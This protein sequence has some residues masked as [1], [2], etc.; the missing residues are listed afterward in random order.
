MEDGMGSNEIYLAC[1][2]VRALVLALIAGALACGSPPEP[3]EYGPGNNGLP[4]RSLLSNAVTLNPKALRALIDNPLND[5]LLD[6]SKH[7]YMSLQ[8]TD[9]RARDVMEYIVSC[10]LDRSAQVKYLEP[11]SHVTH[12]WKGELGL[13]PSW[14]K[15]KPSEECLHLVSSCLFARTNRLGRQ[16]PIRIQGQNLRPRAK[17]EITTKYPQ[18]AQEAGAQG[19]RGVTEGND[20]L[21]FSQGWEPGYV[22][23]CMPSKSITLA[24]PAPSRCAKTSLRVCKGVRGC[25]PEDARFLREKY[26]PCD[27]APLTFT[28]PDQGFYGVMTKS[29]RPA[30]VEVVQRRADAGAYPALE[31]DVFSF[32]EGA[33]FGNLFDPDGLT[34]FREVVLD[35]N[36]PKVTRGH[37]AGTDEGDEDTIPHRHIYSCYSLDNA[38]EGIAY[39]T[40]RICAKP[41][42]G[43]KCF[44]N[45]PQPCRFRDTGEKAKRDAVCR[46]GSKG[47]WDCRGHGSVV[48]PALAVFL[49]EPCGLTES[50]CA[51]LPRVRL[52]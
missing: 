7:P 14:N 12:T 3:L 19:A 8:L 26:G 42:A 30:K 37:L 15:K 45:P 43:K 41:D 46:R 2:P 35:A 28:C 50:G 5:A 32:L 39:L 25:E 13:C 27:D 31:E 22:G 9:S 18:G 17:V 1:A 38:E 34:R 21:A 23:R 44:P 40:G 11:S 52:D 51:N 29:D 49:N 33:F 47:R 6:A 24:I 4:A 36:Q 20:I 10:A 48:Y 16:V